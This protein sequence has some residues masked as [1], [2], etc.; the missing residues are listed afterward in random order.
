[1]SDANFSKFLEVI[2]TLR[3]PEGCPWDRKQ[4]AESMRPYL[5]EETYETLDAIDMHDDA[6]LREELGDVFLIA[7]MV[8]YIKEQEGSFTVGEVFDQIREKLVRR[9]PH[10]FA[11]AEADT[12]EAVS[13][14][15][16]RI[17]TDVEG[18]A[19]PSALDG[20]PEGLPPLSRAYELQKRAEKRG[21]DWDNPRPA[22]AKVTEELDE[23][24]ALDS[25][26]HTRVEA[27]VGD[28]LFS[29]VNL[30]RKMG[31]DPSVALHQ[32]NTKFK[33]RFRAVEEEME[34]RGIDMSSDELET[35]DAIWSQAK[36]TE[37]Q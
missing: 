18:K 25:D 19:H 23:I 35:M 10:V 2:R 7:T 11:S 6:E 8:A 12:P 30:S 27:E 36:R 17:K 9:H 20:V 3:G 4:T 28:L 16:D 34:R 5:L 37:D 1:M 13:A 15:W 22:A 24:L 31:V 26:D 32:A 21:F 14:Q 33:R 29:A